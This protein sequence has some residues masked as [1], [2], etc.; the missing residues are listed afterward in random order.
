MA[1]PVTTTALDIEQVL[2]GGD[3]SRL[4]PE[5]R[6][7]YYNRV[8]ESVGLNPLTRPFDYITLNNKLT[9]YCKRDATD[10][11]RKLNGVSVKLSEPRI[12]DGVCIVRAEAVDKNG[13][14]DEA[15]GAVYIGQLKGE[16]LANAYM[17][18]E[19]KAKRRV[20]LS[21]CGLGWLDETEVGASEEPPPR[22]TRA[23]FPSEFRTAPTVPD[24][25]REHV[26]HDTG[27]ITDEL[28]G[29]ATHPPAVRKVEGA[30]VR[31]DEAGR[32][33]SPRPAPSA[34]VPMVM[35]RCGVTAEGRADW[36]GW[37][38]Q[39]RD[40]VNGLS[41]I[42]QVDAWEGMHTVL[43]NSLEAQSKKTAARFREHLAAT[44]VVLGPP[45]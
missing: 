22:P 41:T 19:T 13:R 33:S 14:S 8:C 24:V 34:P 12:V 16:A 20:T 21:I 10:Q 29:E 30:S 31:T 36:A 26:D 44:R 42:S 6:V 4:N 23:M 1:N 27:E 15:T 5:Q 40:A 32:D 37:L 38:A 18:A 28:A 25:D 17:K 35:I 39:A 45:A 3:L 43:L 11:L 7:T 2:V 9:L